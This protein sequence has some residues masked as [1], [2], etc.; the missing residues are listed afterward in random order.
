MGADTNICVRCMFHLTDCLG[1]DKCSYLDEIDVVTGEP[2][3][4]DCYRARASMGFC[5]PKGKKF[6]RK[7]EHDG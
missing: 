4:S 6:K 2:Y 7:V 3:Y 1:N 5:G